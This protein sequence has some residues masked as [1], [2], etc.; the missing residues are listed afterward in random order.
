MNPILDK[1]VVDISLV[2]SMKLKLDECRIDP[3]FF[4]ANQDFI[5]NL[6]TL[7]LSSFCDDIFNPPVFKRE[8]LEDENECRYLASAEIVLLKPQI[9][10]ITNEQADRLNLRV[11]KK[12]ILVTG[13]GTVG[14]IRI[15]D[16]IINGYAVANNVARVVAKKGFEGFIAAYLESS[17][18]NKLLNDYAAGA[19]VKYIEAPQIAKIPVPVID[20][21]TVI[22]IN[23]LYLKSVACR[24]QSF[25]KLEEADALVLKYNNLPMLSKTEFETID[26]NKQSQIRLTN[27]SEFTIDYRLDAHFYNPI[28]KKALDNLNKYSDNVLFLSELTLDIILGKRFKRNYVE[29]GFGTPFLSGKNIIQIKPFDMNNLSDTEI[30]FLDELI[31][32]KNWSLITCSG[33]LGRTCFVYNNYEGYA[34]SQHILRVA[35]NEDIID[36]GYLFCFLSSDYGFQQI[37]RYK[38]GSVIDEIDDKS[39]AN[40]QVPIISNIKQKEIGDL[41]RQAYDL[42]AE[43][44]KLE[45]GAQALLTQAL[46]KE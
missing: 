31:V 30:D 36:A 3:K 43:A 41:V 21:D 13:F 25:V 10:Y 17:Y 1:Y 42:R 9:T 22:L 45:E 2:S 39:I 38:Y 11:K 6:E 12:W 29:S 35:A 19:V 26:I 18:G 28:A 27:Q 40:V 33:T 23:D 24:E 46:T 7:P 20:T 16:E 14:S 37:V 4:S 15:V 34:A 8:F 44:I 5:N 32:K